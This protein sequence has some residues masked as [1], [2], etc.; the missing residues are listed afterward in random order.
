MSGDQLGL[1]K[2]DDGGRRVDPALSRVAEKIGSHVRFGTSSWTFD[3][4]RGVVYHRTYPSQRAFTRE[5]LR[6]YAKYPLFRC[7]G[8]DRS[9]YAPVPARELVAYAEQVP[10]AFELCQ[11]V[12]STVATRVFPHHERYGERAGRPNPDFLNPTLFLEA[13]GLASV[14]GLGEHLGPFI[15][16]IPAHP[17]RAD[18]EGF[19]RALDTFLADVGA[20]FRIAVELRDRRLYTPGYREVLRQRGATHLFNFWSRMPTI[21]EQLDAPGALMGPF[22]VAR[23]MIPPGRKYE[24]MKEAYAPFDRIHEIQHGMRDD[25]IRLIDE[26]GARDIETYVIA[27]N[28]AEGSSPLTVRGIAE[29]LASRG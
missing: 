13:Q 12:W 20:D 25:V 1:F 3:G 22:V 24:E 14:E 15:L 16:E 27:N 7:V 11:K 10:P 28:K 17:G 2:G 23:L 19:E 6:E 29:R 18:P 5:S 9:Y 8:V 21:G 26:A 4:W